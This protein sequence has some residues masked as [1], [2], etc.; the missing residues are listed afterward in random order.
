[1]A[2][3]LRWPFMFTLIVVNFFFVIQGSDEFINNWSNLVYE[4]ASDDVLGA[5]GRRACI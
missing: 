5:D 1:M 3:R 2:R 4:A